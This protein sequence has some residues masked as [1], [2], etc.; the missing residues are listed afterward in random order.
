MKKNIMGFLTFALI[1]SLALIPANVAMAGD[2][3]LESN[4]NAEIIEY[5]N[6]DVTEDLIIKK[7]SVVKTNDLLVGESAKLT[8]EEGAVLEVE[9]ENIVIYGTF[10]VD[11]KLFGNHIELVH[12]ENITVGVN[13]SVRVSLPSDVIAEIFAK[14]MQKL[15]IDARVINNVAIIQGGHTH[16]YENSVCKICGLYNCELGETE[17]TFKEGI[18]TLCNAVDSSHIH[19]YDN[20][21]C[22]NC[23][24]K[25]LHKEFDANTNKCKVCNSFICIKDGH[26]YRDSKCTVCGI[27]C[28][29]DFHSNIF[30]CPECGMR[31]YP[32]IVG[33]VLSNGNLLIVIIVAVA[34][35]FGVGGFFIGRRK[36]KPAVANDLP[37]VNTEDEDNE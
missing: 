1:F 29:N 2:A 9:N 26:K 13:G 3:N 10:Q 17:H 16:E 20:G 6:L 36:K 4:K 21:V 19:N 5:H 14:E 37:D 18:C 33:T 15:Q 12:I 11:G 31:L 28:K 24:L 30:A 25:C 7:G 22:R 8:I 34:V 35:L 23:G 27:T 32:H